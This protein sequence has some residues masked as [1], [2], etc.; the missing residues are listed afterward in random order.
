MYMNYHYKAGWI[1]KMEHT[2]VISTQMKNQHVNRMPEAPKTS[3]SHK[4]PPLK[5]KHHLDF[6]ENNLE[7]PHRIP[8]TSHSECP[9]N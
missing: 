9:E 2:Y 3:L 7:I 1:L 6:R 8:L 4:H 5:V